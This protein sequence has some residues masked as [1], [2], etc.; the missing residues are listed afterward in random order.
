M[1]CISLC[2]GEGWSWMHARICITVCPLPRYRELLL[3]QMYFEPFFLWDPITVMRMLPLWYITV[4]A[5]ETRLESS[6]SVFVD[7]FRSLSFRLSDLLETS[8]Q[9]W[10]YYGLLLRES[11]CAVSRRC[12]VVST[13]G[14]ML[15]QRS[16][17]ICFLSALR[18]I[19][20]FVAC[21]RSWHTSRCPLSRTSEQF[22]YFPRTKITTSAYR[23]LRLWPSSWKQRWVYCQNTTS[24]WLIQ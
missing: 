3:G 2:V 6:E 4:P 17:K 21:P 24:C 11:C 16:C 12:A 20:S 10:K 19:N 15:A 7:E 5:S 14:A 22:I 13:I 9:A 18:A 1:N 8:Q 23:P